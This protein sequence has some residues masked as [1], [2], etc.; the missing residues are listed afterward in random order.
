MNFFKTVLIGFSLFTWIPFA[1]ANHASTLPSEVALHHLIELIEKN[2]GLFFGTHQDLSPFLEDVFEF[3]QYLPDSQFSQAFH[4]ISPALSPVVEKKHHARSAHL[5]SLWMQP[6]SLLR[7]LPDLTV[8]FPIGW[9]SIPFLRASTLRYLQSKNSQFTEQDFPFLVPFLLN[10]L[11]EYSANEKDEVF[12]QMD[13]PEAVFIGCNRSLP[14]PLL[15]RLIKTL[16]R[17]GKLIPYERVNPTEALEAGNEIGLR[18][19]ALAWNPNLT[20]TQIFEVLDLFNTLPNSVLENVDF[21]PLELPTSPVFKLV[22]HP[23]FNGR[24][25]PQFFEKMKK[26][27]PP[28]FAP[29]AL[30]LLYHPAIQHFPE[31]LSELHKILEQPNYKFVLD[32]TENPEREYFRGKWKS[33]TG[34]RSFSFNW[35]S[36]IFSGKESRRKLLDEALTGPEDTS[37]QVFKKA[38]I[39]FRLAM[40][41]G[42]ENN[43]P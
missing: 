31:V 32:Y 18:L 27:K 5:N 3:S 13:S 9:V 28:V 8:Y 35:I 19:E 4:F 40:T 12:S 43:L 41:V 23:N 6:I 39:Y 2:E 11:F 37:D 1:S 36:R 15:T 20:S 10:P 30:G 38:T 14:Q 16:G 22:D 25:I 21:L 34:N 33:I 17:E 29:A 26:Y 7:K 42:Y 24:E